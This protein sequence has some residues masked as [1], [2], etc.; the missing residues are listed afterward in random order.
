MHYFHTGDTVIAMCVC[1]QITIPAADSFYTID[2]LFGVFTCHASNFFG[3][4]YL[5]WELRKAG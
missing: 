1:P 2:W 4:N 5:S 3:H